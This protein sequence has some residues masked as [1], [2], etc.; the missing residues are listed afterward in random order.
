MEIMETKQIE[1]T[2]ANVELA[3]NN[4][5]KYAEEKGYQVKGDFTSGD[6]KFESKSKEKVCRNYLWRLDKKMGM[7]VAN[8]FL[9]FLYKK[10][11]KTETAPS[12][13]YSEKELKIK[14]ARKAWRKLKEE[15]EKLQAAYKLE[16]GTFYK[17][18]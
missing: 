2:K 11:Y 13:D 17:Q 12:I 18:K 10:V 9:H 15:A 14:E 5:K 6:L 3:I 4:I 7:S 8:R 1:A 16:K